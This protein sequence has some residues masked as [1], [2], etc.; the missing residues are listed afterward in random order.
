MKDNFIELNKFIKTEKLSTFENSRIIIGV[1]LCKYKSLFPKTRVNKNI[2]SKEKNIKKGTEDT[3]QNRIEENNSKE[4][5]VSKKKEIENIWLKQELEGIEVQIR[6]IEH[7]LNLTL[8]KKMVNDLRHER[9][10]VEYQSREMDIRSLCLEQE[11][12]KIKCQK[13]NIEMIEMALKLE[14]KEINI[15]KTNLENKNKTLKQEEEALNIQE[16]TIFNTIFNKVRS[17]KRKINVMNI[18][19]TNLKNENMN[20]KNEN[21]NLKN[22][23]KSREV[24]VKKCEEQILQLQNQN[25]KLKIECEEQTLQLKNQISELKTE[26]YKNEIRKLFIQNNNEEG[27]NKDFYFEWDIDNYS[28]FNDFESEITAL[29]YKWKIKLSSDHSEY[30][31]LKLTTVPNFSFEENSFKYA[32]FVISVRN[33]NDFSCFIAKELI[34]RNAE[35]Y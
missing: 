13:T 12:W 14:R 8:M 21:M 1:Y 33:T 11:K 22:G 16:S 2:V 27:N 3:I 7:M 30:L 5:I 31:S 20:L 32:N 19:N 10:E 4:E 35:D 34:V 24:Y 23:L 18:E 17:Q 29:A 25:S 26:Q 9:E 15:K 6:E 28:K